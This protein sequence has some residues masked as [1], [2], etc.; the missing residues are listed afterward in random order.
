MKK[1]IGLTT[2]KKH[3]RSHREDGKGEDQMLEQHSQKMK[4]RLALR[5]ATSPSERW[6]IKAAERNQELSSNTGPTER[7]EDQDKDGKMT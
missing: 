7:L 1:K 2:K 6:L 5:I 4:W 3:E